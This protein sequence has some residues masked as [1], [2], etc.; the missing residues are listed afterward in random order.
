MGLAGAAASK[1]RRF[2]KP[3]EQEGSDASYPKPKEGPHGCPLGVVNLKANTK[4]PSLPVDEVIN[5]GC[6][7][8][9]GKAVGLKE[10]D[11]DR[12]KGGR[13]LGLS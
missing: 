9:V 12:S 5:A 2:P 13:G 10:A 6:G 7:R 4:E 11:R 3:K 8:T 1:D